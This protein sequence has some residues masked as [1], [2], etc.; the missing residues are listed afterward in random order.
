MKPGDAA[1]T[2]AFEMNTCIQ[3]LPPRDLFETMNGADFVLIDDVLYEANYLRVPDEFTVAD[4]VVLEARHGPTEI[5][6]TRADF[7]G[8]VGVGE[9]VFRL[10]SGSLVRFLAAAVIH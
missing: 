5:D 10:K 8:A 3:A 6:M 2:I 9:G 1:P 4:D 7:D